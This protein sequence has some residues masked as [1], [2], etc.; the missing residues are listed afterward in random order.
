MALGPKHEG[1]F[2]HFLIKRLMLECAL[3]WTVD[4]E[5]E[6]LHDPFQFILLKNPMKTTNFLLPQ[7]GIWTMYPPNTSLTQTSSVLYNAISEIYT[8]SLNYEQQ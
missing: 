7:A 3:N 4:K 1:K 5:F 6:D 2:D 8:R